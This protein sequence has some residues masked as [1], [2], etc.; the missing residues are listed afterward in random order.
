MC[1]TSDLHRQRVGAVCEVL[2][3][4]GARTVLDLGCGDGALLTT[5]VRRECVEQVVGVDLC[6]RVLRS[7]DSKLRGIG[8]QSE[9]VRLVHGSMTDLCQRYRGFDAA[10]LVEAIEHVDLNRLSAVERTLFGKLRPRLVVMTTPNADF[11]HLLGVPPHRFRHPDH[12]FE[13]G[14]AKF[15]RWAA[16]IGDRH[17]YSASFTDIPKAHPALGGPTQM[18]ALRLQG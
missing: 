18:A 15:R 5:L 11:N 16:G 12:R 17:G 2:N 3:S 14:R 9:K 13:W 4:V 8:R 7:L 10:V 1:R 6:A